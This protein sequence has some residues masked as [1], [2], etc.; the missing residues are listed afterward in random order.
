M[1]PACSVGMVAWCNS[2]KSKSILMLFLWLLGVRL[3]RVNDRR[4][5]D[6]VDECNGVKG[7][8]VGESTMSLF[9]LGRCRLGEIEGDIVSFADCRLPGDW[10]FLIGPTVPWRDR[11][12]DL[13]GFGDDCIS[14]V[15]LLVVVLPLM[16]HGERDRRG[17][18]DALLLVLIVI[19]I[20]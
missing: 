7:A 13:V 2:V 4:G 17:D 20:V 11:R 8:F 12:G 6:L 14:F 3:F 15:L 10:L 5:D 16:R 18:L 19:V 1:E 9:A